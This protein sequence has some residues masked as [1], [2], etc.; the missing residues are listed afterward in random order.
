MCYEILLGKHSKAVLKMGVAPRN[1]F[2]G[3]ISLEEGEKGGT[4]KEI[5]LGSSHGVEQ[6][7]MDLLSEIINRI[8]EIYGTEISDQDRLDLEYMKRKWLQTPDYSL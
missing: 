8:N 1:R 4:I 3:T 6:T 2:T 5:Q 7:E